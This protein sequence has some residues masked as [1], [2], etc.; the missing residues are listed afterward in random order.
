MLTLNQI[1]NLILSRFPERNLA[2]EDCLVALHTDRSHDGMPRETYA[3]L[4]PGKLIVWE[5]VTALIPKEENRKRGHRSPAP[6]FEETRFD[7]YSLDGLTGFA[8][9]PFISG[10][11]LSARWKDGNS[12]TL[13]ISSNLSKDAVYDFC[14]ALKEWEKSGNLDHFHVRDRELCCPK[15]GTIYPDPKRKICPKCMD[16]GKI[17]LRMWVF[18]KRYKWKITASVLLMVLVS[19]LGILTP[20]ISSAFFYDQVLDPAVGSQFYGKVALVILLIAS[21]RLL[22]TLFDI[23]NQTIQSIVG[24]RIIYDLRKTIFNAIER[25]SLSFFTNRQT[26]G[27]ITQVN[28]DADSLHWFF[29]DGLPWFMINIVQIIGVTVIMIGI[30]APLS[31]LALCLVPVFF[32]SLIRIHQINGKLQNKR[33][34]SR[35]SL[36]SLLSDVLVGFRVV[37]AF[38]KEKDE[39]AR[40]QSR[41]T[42]LADDTLSLRMFGVYIYPPVYFLLRICNLLVWGFG[43]WMVIQGKITYGILATFVSYT[44]LVHQPMDGLVDI[45]GYFSEFTNASSRLL[46]IMDAEPDV[47]ESENPVHLPDMRGDVSFQNIVFSYE[48]NRKII[49]GI[50][51]DIEAG[52]TIGIVGHTG[53]GK[54]TLAN[55]LI[56]LYDPD[57]GAITIDGVNLQDIAFS[58]LRKNIAIVS[59]ETY[60]F[61]GTIM[62]N[63]RY[64]KPDATKEE[65]IRAAK[66]SGAHDFIVKLPEGYYTMIG[67]GEKN[68]SGGERQRLSIARAILQNPKILILDEATAAMDTETERRIQD[69][70][71]RLADGK[72]TVMIAHRL[73]TLRNADKL[74]V[75]ENGKMPESGTHAELLAK[76]DGIYNKLYRLQ[77]EAM[78]N[79]GVEE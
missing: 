12:L 46:E 21:A 45:M 9:D 11:R 6:R 64:A 14:S 39:A 3:F 55:L 52:K 56:R 50:S 33:Y 58:D 54:S 2:E 63:I 31:I 19:A 18:C 67:E 72:T 8:V 29:T 26:G 51:F 41:N 57:E 61:I 1:P 42:R 28:S 24:S 78:K 44:N 27:L 4:F 77:L 34:S 13:L 20:Y 75:I 49:D 68:L 47:R 66:M 30:N 76:K 60:L 48:K 79:I 70:L 15:C 65:I 16:K 10:V 32:S 22:S 35:K 62:D 43:G 17:L 23:L 53:A 71:D 25:L 38:S 36:T 7:E 37:K 59:Q 40:F 69:A 5:G 74:I 73:S